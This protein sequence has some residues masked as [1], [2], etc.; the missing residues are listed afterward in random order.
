MK[1]RDSG[2]PDEVL[3]ESL[4]DVELLL[5]RLGIDN[6]LGDVAELGCGF[7]T[8]TVPVAE[9]ISG[10]L[11]AFDIDEVMVARTRTRVAQAGLANVIVEKRDVLA[12]GFGL[13]PASQQGCL[14]FNI[15]HHKDPVALLRMTARCL[16]PGGRLFAVHWRHDPATPRGPSLR[17]RPRPTQI[18]MWARES[19][20]LDVAG[21]VLDLPPWHYGLVL[22]RNHVSASHDQR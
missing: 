20:M 13:A 9:R 3:W 2:M 10:A 11:H 6:G 22:A 18:G 4:F 17:I 5:R 14:L 16:L 21:E 12:G 15:L 1:V 7:G 19:G 8:F